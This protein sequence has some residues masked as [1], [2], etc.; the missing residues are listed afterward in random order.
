MSYCRGG[1]NAFASV[2][3]FM[4]VSFRRV[5]DFLAGH[6]RFV[7]VPVFGESGIAAGKHEGQR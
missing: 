1:Q 4:G 2:V 3:T 6:G 7:M 5:A